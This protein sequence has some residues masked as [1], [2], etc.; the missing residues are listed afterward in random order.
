MIK[1]LDLSSETKRIW[2]K[3]YQSN[4]QKVPFLT[5]NWH[6]AWFS[7][8]GKQWQPLILEIDEA[9]IAPF[10]RKNN[11]I[12]F[13][14]GDEIADYLDIIGP[15]KLKTAAWNAIIKE[16][17]ISGVT[18]I[19]LRN[20]PQSSASLSAL[21]HT[22]T[23][24]QEDTTPII[25]LPASWEEYI[26]SLNH[27]HRHELRRKLRKFEFMHQGTQITQ[28]VATKENLSDLITLMRLDPNK[29]SFLTPQVEHFFLSLP[30]I[31]ANQAEVTTL[32]VNSQIAATTVSFTN[33]STV[34]LYNSGFNEKDFSGAGF[35]IKAI[36]IKQT[37][38]NGYKTYNFLQGSER[39]KYELGGKDFAVYKI[40]ITL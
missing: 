38:E 20:L 14:G 1:R 37:I 4:S 21:K 18:T 6:Q 19:A 27:K 28:E 7:I 33:S 31:L 11:Q 25:A 9:I 17:K 8:L 26:S 29:Q 10:A 30:Q 36:T 24:T 39:Y 22:A 2:E 15:E 40:V 32:R 35:Y 16:F 13:S 23:V 12:I 34:F 5:Y 3:I